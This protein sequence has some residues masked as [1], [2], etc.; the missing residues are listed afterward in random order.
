MQ[1]IS[2][3]HAIPISLT[4]MDHVSVPQALFFIKTLAF[5]VLLVT[6]NNALK[7]TSVPNVSPVIQ[8]VHL[9]KHASLAI[10]KAVPLVVLPI[11]VL[12]AQEDL[13]RTQM[14]IYV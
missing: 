4:P 2:A 5:H 10:F 12:L 14:E 7:P 11:I 8:L 6:A 13:S 3:M 9:E 1:P